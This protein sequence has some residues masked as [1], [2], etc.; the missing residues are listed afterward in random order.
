MAERLRI[1]AVSDGRAGVENQALGLAEAV[2]RQRPADVTVKR[3]AYGPVL[4]R[5]PSLLNLFPRRALAA[6]ADPIEPPWPD[7][8]IAAGRATLALSIRVRTWSQRRSFVVQAQDPRL[9]ARLFDLVIPPEHDRLRGANV[10]PLIGAPNRAT[11]ERLA[12]ERDRFAQALA[13]LPHPRVAVLIGGRSRA[14]DLSEARAEALATELDLALEKAGAA[15]LMSFSRRTPEAAKAVLTQRLKRRP[16]LIWDGAGENPFFA[17]LGAADVVAVTEDSTNMAAEAAGTGKPVLVLKLDGD[18]RRLRK[19]HTALQACGAA[20]PFAGA[21]DS[22][23]YEPLR[24][25]DRA[26]AE[27]LR[28]MDLREL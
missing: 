4:A 23:D 13:P 26:A 15:L 20:R 6:G 7:L 9:P 16:G 5:L 14:F 12:A 19:F 22:W 25:T 11:P 21:F 27:I 17:F 8:W 10:L 18:S 2:A 1:W 3:I 28:R 24:E